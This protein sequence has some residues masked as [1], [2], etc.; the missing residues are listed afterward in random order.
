MNSE[1][2]FW[3]YIRTYGIE[4]PIVQR[5]YAQGRKGKEYLRE[6]FLKNLKQALDKN[7]PDS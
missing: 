7:L 4:I 5:D 2:S 3:K 1:I 6:S